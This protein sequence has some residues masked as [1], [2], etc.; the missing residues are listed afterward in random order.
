MSEVHEF[1]SIS[2]LLRDF[3][4]LLEFRSFCLRQ[5]DLVVSCTQKLDQDFD[6]SD[7]G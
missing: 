7:P 4:V 2:C 3:V 1:D 5:F 6:V